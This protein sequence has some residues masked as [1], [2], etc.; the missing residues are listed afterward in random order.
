MHDV[1]TQP[2]TAKEG[3]SNILKA[4]RLLNL[5]HVDGLS[6]V[7]QGLVRQALTCL[8]HELNPEMGGEA[9]ARLW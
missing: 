7:D 8:W 9:K 4:I 2:Q 5:V 3:P 6:S 1:L